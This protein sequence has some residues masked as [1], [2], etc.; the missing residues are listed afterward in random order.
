MELVTDSQISLSAFSGF[1]G[2]DRA[3]VPVSG[4]VRPKVVDRSICIGAFWLSRDVL[5]SLVCHRNHGRSAMKR[6]V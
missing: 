5:K 4:T 2:P 1:W 6:R 3:A